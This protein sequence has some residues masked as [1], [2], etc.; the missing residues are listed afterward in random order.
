[1]MLIEA[2]WRSRVIHLNFM[3]VGDNVAHSCAVYRA[4]IS[5]NCQLTII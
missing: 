2:G 5:N 3:T 4:S 1:M